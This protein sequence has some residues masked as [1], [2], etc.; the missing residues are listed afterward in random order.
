MAPV[1]KPAQRAAIQVARLV[2]ATRCPADAPL[3]TRPGRSRRQPPMIH[4]LK[5]RT[6]R[7]YPR[8]RASVFENANQWD[9]T[10]NA[11]VPGPSDRG[12][13]KS[14]RRANR[15]SR[16]RI[17]R[18]CIVPPFCKVGGDAGGPESVAAGRVRQ[19]SLPGAP[20]D[21]TAPANTP[22]GAGVANTSSRCSRRSVQ[23]RSRS[24]LRKI[25]PLRSSAIRAHAR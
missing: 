23:W 7:K 8:Q 15:R 4:R 11:P 1:N 14:N 17:A 6:A 21:H 2:N 13:V 16:K 18:V 10:A 19:P 12:N 24:R 9:T 5:Q 22:V 20:L 25:G 3:L